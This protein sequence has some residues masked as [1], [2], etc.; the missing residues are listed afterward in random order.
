MTAE[1]LTPDERQDRILSLLADRRRLPVAGLAELFATS[2]D[3]IR[4]DLRALAA[5]GKIRRVHGAV[6]PALP[7]IAAFD[8]RTG[9]RADG[10]DA[11]ARAVIRL[12]GDRRT[13]SIDGGTTTLAVARAL[14]TDRRLQ[15]LT[16]SLPV[17]LALADNPGAEVV[18]AGGR[19]DPVSRT[20]V[21]PA[22][23]EAIRRFRP[24]LCLLGLCSIDPEAGITAVGYEEAQVKAAMIE[25]AAETVAVA[26][27]EKI[28]AVSANVVGPAGSVHRL[29]TDAAPPS[30]L[31]AA[32]AAEGIEIVL[33]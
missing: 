29:V 13:L 18:L 16:T 10:K 26:T 33:A 15:I 19:F 20:T 5:A 4:R 27:A 23:I 3:S 30:A 32:L 8:D 9:A 6:L 1:T 17:A 2:E 25:A 12:L 11:I 31:A 14:P 7:P 21:G 22:A 24:D 28:G